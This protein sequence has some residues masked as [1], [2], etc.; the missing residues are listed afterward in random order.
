MR[1]FLLKV[2]FHLVENLNLKVVKSKIINPKS[3]ISRNPK[4][5]L[6][7]ASEIQNHGLTT[8]TALKALLSTMLTSAASTKSSPV[9]SVLTYP[10]NEM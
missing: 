5:P 6:R 2:F 3:K 8:L 1:T 4:S 7:E 10:L 9:T